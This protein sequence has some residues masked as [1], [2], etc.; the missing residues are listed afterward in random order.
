MLT[1]ILH[2]KAAKVA[3]DGEDISWRQLFRQREDLMTAA[4]FLDVFP[5]FLLQ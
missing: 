4:F 1:A 3:A 2:G 5:I